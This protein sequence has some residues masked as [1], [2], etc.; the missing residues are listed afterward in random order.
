M[1]SK[2]LETLESHPFVREIKARE[3]AERLE[4][5]RA[6]EETIRRVRAQR[7]EKSA[8]LSAEKEELER[9]LKESED[10]VEELR[11]AVKRVR[12][13]LFSYGFETREVQDARGILLSTYD[14]RRDDA[15]EH[16]QGIH[17]GLRVAEPRSQV[18]MGQSDPF[19]M[20]RPKETWTN[21]PALQRAMAYVTSALK[22]IEEMKHLA[23][24][25]EKRIQELMAGVPALDQFETVAGG[26]KGIP[27]PVDPFL[28]S[29]KTDWHEQFVFDE[30]ME[31]TRK[32]EKDRALERVRKKS[33]K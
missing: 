12:G 33:G 7:A 32:W 10:I 18:F 4:K 8:E 21:A 29:L 15:R 25:P 13:Q 2:L 1:D 3:E 17:D 14:P 5:R 27:M 23:D 19:T 31:K 24:F 20:T 22:E 28:A 11:G 9:Q 6:A 30:L 26:R 16:F